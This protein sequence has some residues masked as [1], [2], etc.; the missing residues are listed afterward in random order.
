MTRKLLARNIKN[1]AAVVTLLAVILF[2]YALDAFFS[3]ILI[4]AL[5]LYLFMQI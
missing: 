1:I 2:R 3:G 5:T 4:G